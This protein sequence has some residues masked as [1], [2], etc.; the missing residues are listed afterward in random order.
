MPNTVPISGDSPAATHPEPSNLAVAARVAQLL[1]TEHEHVDHAD[2]FAVNRAHGALTE[3]LRIL[4]RAAGAEPPRAP[5]AELHRLCRDDYTSSADRR[6]QH[7]RDDAR[8]TENGAEAVAARVESPV[9][10]PAAHGDDPTPCSGPPTVTILDATN[11]GARGCEH[12]GA[13]LLASLDGG[14]VYGLPDA[15]PGTAIRVF[16]AAAGIRPFPWVDGP[17]TRDDQL[18][19]DEVRARGEQQ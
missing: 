15:A 3:A 2:L 7:H 17:R 9:R 16:K 8:L 12:H 11:A 18:S 10:C 19:R 1:L 13:R 6:T 5:V 4:L 14:R